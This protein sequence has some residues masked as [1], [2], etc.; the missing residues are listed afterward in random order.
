[1]TSFEPD[2]EGFGDSSHKTSRND[3]KDKLISSVN[4]DTG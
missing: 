4:Y 2:W 1:M 3:V